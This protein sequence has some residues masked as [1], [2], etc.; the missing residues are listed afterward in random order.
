MKK[1]L[2]VLLALAFAGC[3]KSLKED[4]RGQVVAKGL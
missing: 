4:P 3:K 2:F 1:I